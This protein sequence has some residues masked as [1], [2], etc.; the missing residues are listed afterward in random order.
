MGLRTSRTTTMRPSISCQI[1]SS[2][3][4]VVIEGDQ[5]VDLDKLHRVLA[6]ALDFGPYYG[7][8]MSA[9]WDRLTTDVE[10]PVDLVWRHSEQSR[11]AIGDEAYGRIRSLLLEVEEMDLARP[12]GHRFTV[13]FE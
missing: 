12:A 1:G 6:E 13:R 5:I 2:E 10:R 9:L 8:N 7:R 11:L 4:E 3:M